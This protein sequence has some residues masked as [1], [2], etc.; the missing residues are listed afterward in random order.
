[1]LLLRCFLSLLCLLMATSCLGALLTIEPLVAVAHADDDDDDDGGDDDDDDDDRVVRRKPAARIELVAIGLDDGASERLTRRGY[2]ILTRTRSELLDGRLVTRILAPS[3]RSRAASLR[4]I[5]GEAPQ[6]TVSGND[7]YR[8][9]TFARYNTESGGCGTACPA[10]A[11][12]GWRPEAVTCS[13]RIRLGMIDTAVD[14]SHPAL[15]GASIVIRTVRRSDR[16]ASDAAHG[17]GVASVL[18]GRPQSAAPGVIPQAHVLAADAFHRSGGGDAADAFDL[19]IALDWLAAERADVINMSLSGPPNEVLEAAVAATLARDIAI[20][21]AAGRSGG[22]QTGYPARYSG[23]TAVTGIDGRLRALRS[24]NRGPHIAFAAPGAGI[25][26]AGRNGAISRVDGTSFAAPFVSAAIALHAASGTKSA[27]AY[28][29]VRSVVND[30]GAPGRD[31]VFGW[32][33]I[34]YRDLPAC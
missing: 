34:Q 23:V 16:R 27:T 15:D 6:A 4:D 5:R 21:A 32:G 10:F 24:S 7:L 20:V 12:S 30:L 29:R 11:I 2:R 31:P 17:T 1:M 9:H 19:V 14:A 28:D 33:L 22:T 8:R 25:V 26:V 3:G 18:V 13:S